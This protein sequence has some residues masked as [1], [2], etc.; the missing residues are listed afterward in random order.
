MVVNL[1]GRRRSGETIGGEDVGKFGEKVGDTLRG[2]WKIS[3]ERSR[4]RRIR[5]KT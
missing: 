1:V 2:R 5:G 4:R 3:S